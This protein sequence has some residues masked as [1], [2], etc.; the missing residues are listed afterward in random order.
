M[1]ADLR[2]TGQVYTVADGQSL[3]EA[4]AKTYNAKWQE[5]M[6]VCAE[7]QVAG[8]EAEVIWE[9]NFSDSLR[10]LFNKVTKLEWHL[11]DEVKKHLDP[12]HERRFSESESRRIVYSIDLPEQPDEF[13]REL[14]SII[15]VIDNRVRPRLR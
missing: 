9:K 11:H 12:K 6:R 5:I 8:I 15:E 13:R 14:D 3:A 10:P 4:S 1:I 2:Q 7:L